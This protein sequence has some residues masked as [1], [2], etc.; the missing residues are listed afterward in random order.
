MRCDVCSLQMRRCGGDAMCALWRC[1]CDAM[2][3]LCRYGGDAMCALWR[4]GGDATCALCTVE[5]VLLEV[6]DVL[7]V[8]EVMRCVLLHAG[9]CRGWAMFC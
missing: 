8:T 3:A 4:C 1:G 9:C 2:S 6:F 7:E 5:S